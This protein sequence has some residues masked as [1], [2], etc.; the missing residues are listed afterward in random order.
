M[1]LFIYTFILSP[2]FVFLAHILVLFFPSYRNALAE[3][4]RIIRKL[5]IWRATSENKKQTVLIHSSSMGEFEHVKPLIKK[6]NEE[7]D[8]NIIVTFFSPSGYEN[9]KNHDGISL[10][11]YLPFDFKWLWK[12]FFLITQTEILI[13]SKHDVWINQIIVAK[14]LG[15][16]AYLVNASLSTKSSRSSLLA[17][18]M[19]S[20]AYQSLD[21][22]FT[23][24]EE[25]K[26]HFR[27]SFNCENTIV[28]GDTK[29][30]QVTIRKEGSSQNEIIKRDWLQNNTV[31]LFGSLW[32]EDGQKVLPCLSDVLMK[33][34]NLKII[35]APH[36]PTNEII[37]QLTS[38]LRDLKIEYFSQRNFNKENNVLI[39]DRVGILADLYKYADLAYVGGSFKQ[40]IHNVMEPAI[41]G[42]P[43]LYGPVH[44][45]SYEAVRLA[46][47]G[48]SKVFTNEDEF[49]KILQ[50]LINNPKL[51]EQIGEKGYTFAIKNTGAT[52][53]IIKSIK[54]EI[55]PN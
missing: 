52:D 23:I 31:L 40:G 17:R 3:R 39:I 5:R 30:D 15:V 11:I 8:V 55:K 32:P 29:F 53:K 12:K 13:I 14:K 1:I 41:Y 25:D 38:Y 2:L 6:L 54:S 44:G 7:F 45:N 50:E 43:V 19:L 24:S 22:I 4:Y 21:I 42:I 16:H 51:R 49:K 47:E 33:E 18:L 35:I 37:Y 48:G 27:K 10:F 28:V 34:N 36:Q 9:I 26:L 20:K 46:E